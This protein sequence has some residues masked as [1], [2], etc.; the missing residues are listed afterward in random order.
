MYANA[1]VG[2]NVK[3]MQTK[4]LPRSVTSCTSGG[5]AVVCPGVALPE[6]SQVFSFSTSTP[7]ADA[8]LVDPG[9][10]TYEPYFG[11]RE[12][13]F[14]LSPDPRFFFSHSSQRATFD[15]LVAGIRRREGILVLTGEVGAGKTTLCRS[16]LKALDRKTFAA[17]VP[18]PFLSREDLLKTLLVDF[19][20]VS[21]DEIRSGRLQNASRTD[22]SYPLYE[23]LASLQ[24]LHAFAVVII[25]EAQNLP[26]QLLEEI[27]IL[28]DM[29]DRQKL[30]QVLLVGQPEL[31][32]S[33]STYEMRQLRQRLSLQCELLPLGRGDVE[34]YITHRLMVAGSNKT[35]RFSDAAVDRVW[36]VSSG[37]PRIV[38]LVCDRAL[39]NA[40]ADQTGL[41][42][43]DHVAAAIRVL[44][45][46]EQQPLIVQPV[47][48]ATRPEEQASDL[49]AEDEQRA[50]SL[51][52]ESLDDIWASKPQDAYVPED[53]SGLEIY[54]R[55][56]VLDAAASASSLRKT[57]LVSVAVLLVV[58]LGG[59][60]YLRWIGTAQPAP[61]LK[62]SASAQPASTPQVD[63]V[64]VLPPVEAAQ[65]AP[66]T[67]APPVTAEKPVSVPERGVFAIQ[68]AT[69]ETSLGAERA[70]GELKGLGFAAFSREVNLNSGQ[71][72]YAVFV[73]PYNEM[74][75]A[76]R[77][78]EQAQQI[79]GYTPGR[80]VSVT[81]TAS[82]VP[83]P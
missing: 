46:Q 42:T 59:W 50:V 9:S 26:P 65:T 74:T 67:A 17:F 66:A 2:R 68:M 7:S 75:A 43:A 27:R 44:R 23:F 63:L 31:E 19:G 32:K 51:N 18:D 24:A 64:P 49:H 79:R 81:P 28:A 52:L 73:G 61:E 20:V 47:A 13:P 10:L 37:I 11:L 33:I 30:L 53:R 15:S 1:A 25:D 29:E 48:P 71:P 3:A 22:L 39:A 80:I 14:S 38:N 83:L 4:A 41:V 69:L 12:K 77:D 40:A 60:A 34:P 35:I 82:A 21:I 6:H 58:W 57:L 56:S 62:P 72:A 16:V 45:L 70:V 55:E 54:E 5:F 36:G 8:N 76:Q 78:L